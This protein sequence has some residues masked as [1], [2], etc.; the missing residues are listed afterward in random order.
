MGVSMLWSFVQYR[1]FAQD[2]VAA[3]AR[4]ELSRAQADLILRKVKPPDDVRRYLA[5]RGDHLLEYQPPGAPPL[6]SLAS[7]PAVVRLTL[8]GAQDLG[9]LAVH[10]ES[11]IHS[12]A[13]IV[14]LGAFF[15]AL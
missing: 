6:R 2:I 15:V 7:A 4:T 14:A 13:Q 12:R 5:A 11:R 3:D 1:R 9:L 8:G 10:P